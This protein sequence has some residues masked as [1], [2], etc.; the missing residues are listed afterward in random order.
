M[1]E[2]NHETDTAAFWDRLS[3][4]NAGLLGT[5]DGAA[6][7]VPMSH[8]LL[9][10]D[11]TIWF[12][13][14]RDTDLAQAVQDGAQPAIFAL[15]EGGKGLFAII[16]G[17]LAANHD[18]AMRDALWSTMADSWFEQGKSD[19]EVCILALSPADAEVWLPPTSGVQVAF[20][21]VRAQVTGE[22]P[23][24]G[25]HVTLTQADLVRGRAAA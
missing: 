20:N 4:I 22:Q 17:T 24:M 19:P 2:P 25:S 12:I 11:P 9:D 14:S 23:D 5:D 10:G 3:D 6:R 15:A 13:T 16:R 1:H 21:V 8:Q 18:P 7:M